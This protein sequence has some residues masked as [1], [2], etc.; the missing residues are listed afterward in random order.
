MVQAAM[1]MWFYV[2]PIVCAPNALEGVGKWLDL[3]PL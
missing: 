2:T 1:L 3:N